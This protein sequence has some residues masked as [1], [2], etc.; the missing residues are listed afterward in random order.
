MLLT[1]VDMD[2]RTWLRCQLIGKRRTE[3][4]GKGERERM[5]FEEGGR[6]VKGELD[7]WKVALV[8][9]LCKARPDTMKVK[10][11]LTGRKISSISL[12]DSFFSLARD[13][14]LG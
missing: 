11:L 7:L 8:L 9:K 6:R 4:V 10:T 5:S 13:G 12:S 1:A 2:W 3:A 14:G